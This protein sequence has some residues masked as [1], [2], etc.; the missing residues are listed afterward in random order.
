MPSTSDRHAARLVL[1]SV[2]EHADSER[3]PLEYC[4]PVLVR[5]R[6]CSAL[7]RG[8]QGGAGV[9]AAGY[10]VRVEPVP[11]GLCGQAYVEDGS[12]I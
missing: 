2:S 5:R 1:Q 8:P 3:L 6:S 10:L 11:L 7:C 4:G 9:G 12:V